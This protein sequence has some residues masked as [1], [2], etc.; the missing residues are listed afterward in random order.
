M[1]AAAIAPPPPAPPSVNPVAAGDV[2]M[3]PAIYFTTDSL[4]PTWHSDVYFAEFDIIGLSRP[5]LAYD[6]DMRFSPSIGFPGLPSI[7][8]GL[9]LDFSRTHFGIFIFAAVRGF[10]HRCAPWHAYHPSVEVGEDEPLSFLS[11]RS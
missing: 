8:L 3:E 5:T 11:F 2:V 10:S 9:R 1:A 4:M 6:R 7:R